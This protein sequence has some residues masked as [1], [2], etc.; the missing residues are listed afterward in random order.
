M[1]PK[2]ILV[3]I[4]ILTR[5]VSPVLFASQES[6]RQQVTISVPTYLF[7]DSDQKDLNFSFSDYHS[8]AESNS[9]TVVYQVKSNGL[10]QS[11]GAPAVMAKLDGSL[12]DMELQVKV[13]SYSKEGGNSELA[14]V[15]GDFVTLN[16]SD[17]AIAKK[18]NSQGDGKLLRGQ[19]AMTYKAIATSNLTAG[20]YAR[21][22]TL[23]LTDV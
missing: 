19:I 18:A 21:Q 12:P 8:G 10:M 20:E 7:F 9:Q 16:E 22:L 6:F 4:L 23:T 3:F 11:E 13:G 15:S 14:P 17:I 2:Q 5:A 1:K